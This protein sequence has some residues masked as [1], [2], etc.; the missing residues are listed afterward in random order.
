MWDIDTQLGYLLCWNIT[1]CDRMNND[2]KNGKVV[3]LC[4]DSM[5]KQ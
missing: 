3:E 2:L 5:R 4:N 1:F